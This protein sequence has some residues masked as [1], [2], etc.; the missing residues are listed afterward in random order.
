MIVLKRVAD[1]F[2]NVNM[3]PLY[4]VTL[5]RYQPSGMEALDDSNDSI[6]DNYRNK[7]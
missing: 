3:H 5:L 4:C 6:L 1:A 7:S 2:H